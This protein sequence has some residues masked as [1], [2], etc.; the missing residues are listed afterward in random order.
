MDSLIY[1]ILVILATA[2]WGGL[3]SLL[4][5]FAAKQLARRFFGP[6]ADRYYRLFFVITSIIT[7]TPIL[8]MIAYLPSRLLWTISSPWLFLTLGIQFLAV[9]LMVA[10]TLETDV[11]TFA[12]IRQVLHPNRKYEEELVV[13]GFYRYVRHPLYFFSII[14]FWLFPFMT[15]LTLAFFLAGTLYFM[16]GTIPEERKLLVTFGEA[17]RQYRQEVPWLI[18]HFRKNK[19]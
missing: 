16:I 9:V 19:K 18:P 2:A 7:L 4:A 3:H 5:S 11:M 15:D 12:G 13:N 10:T 17:Y 14:I 8:A 1:P 6:K